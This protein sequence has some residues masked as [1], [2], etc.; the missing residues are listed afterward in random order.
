VATGV[1]ADWRSRWVLVGLLSTATRSHGWAIA[2]GMLLVTGR[3]KID[4]FSMSCWLRVLYVRAVVRSRH[5]WVTSLFK[6]CGWVIRIRPVAVIGRT[7]ASVAIRTRSLVL[8]RV[9]SHGSGTNWVWCTEYILILIQNSGIV[10][11]IQYDFDS[12]V[13][14]FD[15]LFFFFVS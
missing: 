7:S 5:G 15:F 2:G 4:T 9:Y 6:R 8:V 1:S 12:F 11:S 13:H 3:D 10:P 14:C